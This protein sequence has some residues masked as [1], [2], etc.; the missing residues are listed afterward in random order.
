MKR[1]TDDVFYLIIIDLILQVCFFGVLLSVAYGALH[2]VKQKELSPAERTKLEELKKKAGVSNLTEL[3]DTLMK[4]GPLNELKGNS[5]FLQKNGG[6][7]AVEK[8]LKAV[9]QAGGVDNIQ[10]MG[11]ELNRL[12]GKPTCPVEA[13]ADWPHVG[14]LARIRGTDDRI[15]FIQTSPKFN[16]VLRKIGRTSESVKDLSTKEFTAVFSPLK[17]GD[18]LYSLDFEEQT[19]LVHARVAMANIFYYTPIRKR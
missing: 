18:C 1:Q 9:E 16:E 6:K 19:D 13:S 5:E 10:K 17:S 7:A 15:S 8:N 11:D 4:L 2:K 12:K 3:T 14:K